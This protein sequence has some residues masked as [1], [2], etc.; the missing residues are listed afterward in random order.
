[1]IIDFNDFICIYIQHSQEV[2]WIF[3]TQVSFISGE[4]L[5]AFC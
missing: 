5:F 3:W 2:T 1:M 4:K